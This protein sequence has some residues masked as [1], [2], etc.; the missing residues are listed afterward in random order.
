MPAKALEGF[1]VEAGE[2]AMLPLDGQGRFYAEDSEV[3]RLLPEQGHLGVVAGRLVLEVLDDRG[4]PPFQRLDL[5]REPLVLLPEQRVFRLGMGQG[6]RSLRRRGPAEGSSLRGGGSIRVVVTC[7]RRPEGFRCHRGA[8]ATYT[9][10]SE[11][12]AR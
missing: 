2:A 10:R 6:C 11:G 1:A 5:L 12:V 8:H 9:Q 4:E 3:C 7:F